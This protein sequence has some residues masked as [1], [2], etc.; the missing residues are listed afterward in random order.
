MSSS[1]FATLL[2]S[3]MGASLQGHIDSSKSRPCNAFAGVE[4]PVAA[5]SWFGGE[6]FKEVYVTVTGKGSPQGV[7]D[8]VA[9]T[10]TT[11]NTD[12]DIYWQ[13]PFEPFIDQKQMWCNFE[14]AFSPYN[15]STGKKMGIAPALDWAHVTT[16]GIEASN[17][18]GEYPARCDL[19]GDFSIELAGVSADLNGGRPLLGGTVSWHLDKWTSVSDDMQGGVSTA[20]LVA[21][22]PSGDSLEE[23][24]TVSFAVPGHGSEDPKA[25]S[26]VSSALQAA[27]ATADRHHY[28][29]LPCLDDEAGFD[30]GKYPNPDMDYPYQWCSPQCHDLTCSTDVP[31]STKLIPQCYAHDLSNNC[32]LICESSKDCPAGS[33]CVAAGGSGGTFCAYPDQASSLV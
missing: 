28:G 27:S 24:S 2:A 13:C 15:R 3:S 17:K 4:M 9:L 22:G 20:S 11:N 12:K 1:I 21:S 6:R 26:K 31:P 5:L 23:Q 10:L 19:A 32:L 7:T 33:E 8:R 14:S 18:Y 16:I 30:N 29:S 25:K